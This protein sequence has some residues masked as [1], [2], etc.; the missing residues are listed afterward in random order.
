MCAHFLFDGNDMRYE[1][2]EDGNGEDQIRMFEEEQKSA[3]QT[4][5]FVSQRVDLVVNEEETIRLP[6]LLER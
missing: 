1:E 3:L 5:E 2:Y 4:Q 6:C